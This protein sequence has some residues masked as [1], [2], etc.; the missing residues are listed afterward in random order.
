MCDLPS[1]LP[2]STLAPN[3]STNITPEELS[4]CYYQL[5]RTSNRSLFCKIIQ[6]YPLIMDTYVLN[7]QVNVEILEIILRSGYIPSGEYLY[8]I[9]ER[10]LCDVVRL[11]CE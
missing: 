6:R 9:C 5:D 3:M 7:D 11:L 10:E 4:A 1:S 2:Y 8:R